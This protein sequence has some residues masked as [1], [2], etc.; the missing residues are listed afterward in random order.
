MAT[1]SRM[2]FPGGG[3]SD[4]LQKIHEIGPNAFYAY[5]G[6]RDLAEE[7]VIIARD[8]ARNADMMRDPKALAD[9]LD[10]QSLPAM[11]RTIARTE[12]LRSSV[13]WCEE[14][15]SGFKSF[16]GYAL[17][18]VSCGISGFVWRDFKLEN[19]LVV[20]QES[21]C[22]ESLAPGHATYCIS[23]NRHVTHLGSDPK[24]WAGGPVRAS[25]LLIGGVRKALPDITGGQTQMVV[26]NKCGGSQWISR[27]AATPVTGA[28]IQT[29]ANALKVTSTG[30][31]QVAYGSGVQ[32]NGSGLVELA[33]DSAS[34]FTFVSG[35]LALA[36]GDGLTVSGG[37][38]QANVD[39]TT[40]SF[41][42]GVM[43]IGGVPLSKLGGGT[44]NLPAGWTYAGDVAV[45]QLAVGGNAYF[46]G[47]AV[48]A[49][50]ATAPFV[51][52]GSAG[53]IIGDDYSA[54][55][56]TVALSASGASI[57]T[58]NSSYAGYSSGTSY[59]VGNIVSSNS[60]N[61]IS[62]VNSNLGNTPASSPTKWALINCVSISA[63]GVG[64]Y[65]PNGS[66]TATSGGVLITNGQGPYVEMTT[67][68]VTIDGGGNTLVATSSAVTIT[69]GSNSLTATGSAVTIT[70]GSNSFI[71][72]G[73]AVTLTAG[74]AEVELTASSL[75]LTV[76][77]STSK[78]T[79]DNAGNATFVGTSGTSTLINGNAIASGSISVATT[80]LST[81]GPIEVG[82]GL[83]ATYGINLKF[84]NASGG[85]YLWV[86]SSGRLRIK[87]GA[88]TSDTDG[89]VVGTQS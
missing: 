71:A 63:S 72:T 75:A 45:S 16:H 8:L 28:R 81:N 44:G 83:A 7:Q 24:T 18:F 35:Q 33:L 77:S 4:S 58:Y 53:I 62:L 5:S 79:L 22:F 64:I 19:G 82:N 73:S 69:A 88:P 68:E 15:A 84:I 52:F 65:G 89:T 48:F 80:L 51:E 17:A 43:E 59:S 27:L 13:S 85:F 1:D 6:W 57:A 29:P 49:Y 25:E 60:F 11:Q 66:V 30:A 39:G 40:I 70:A 10:R 76:N 38:L 50:G 2:M 74:S 23:G 54:P 41:S 14:E 36:S 34:P 21:C 37:V 67:T 20:Q 9:E 56:N 55:V 42:G 46:G 12:G 47:N 32:D 31:I 86:D 78:I 87:A 26:I 61:Y 3:F